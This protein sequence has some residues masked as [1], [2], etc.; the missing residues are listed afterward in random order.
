LERVGDHC[1]NVCER[2][3]FIVEGETNI[4]LKQE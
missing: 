4:K 3:V 1:S 2:I